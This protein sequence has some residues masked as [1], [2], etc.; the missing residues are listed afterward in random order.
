MFKARYQSAFRVG[1]PLSCLWL[2]LCAP[3]PARTLQVFASMGAGAKSDPTRVQIA[4]IS[5][6]TYDPLARAVRRKLRA[7]TPSVTDG[8]FPCP[9]ICEPTSNLILLW[10]LPSLIIHPTPFE[11]ARPALHLNSPAPGIP[12]VY[13]TEIPSSDIGLLP[14]PQEEFEKGKVQELAPFDEF[15]VRILPVLGTS[16]CQCA[17]A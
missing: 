17:W 3:R 14:L 16:S 10:L 1:I 5:Q 13:S 15:R 8:T 7:G 11:C 6:T 9:Y 12:V 4:D 2:T